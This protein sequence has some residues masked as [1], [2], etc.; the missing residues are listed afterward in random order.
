M[1]LGRC[2]WGKGAALLEVTHRDVE[3]G[4]RGVLP[5]SM[6]VWALEGIP[7]LTGHPGR[8]L[9]L[10]RPVTDGNA[11]EV[12]ETRDLTGVSARSTYAACLISWARRG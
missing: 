1:Y 5:G 12:G 4:A 3:P 8:S 9:G 11:Q 10:Q 6:F 7:G 2:I